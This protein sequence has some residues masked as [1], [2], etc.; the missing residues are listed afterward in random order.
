MP[1]GMLADRAPAWSRVVARAR[2]GAI[3]DT[4]RGHLK[5][6]EEAVTLA[7]DESGPPEAPSLLCV[8]DARHGRWFWEGLRTAL[9]DY[10][11][12]V[13]DLPGHG[14]SADLPF[15]SIS[16]CADRLVAL[17]RARAHKRVVSAIGVGLGAQI[18]LDLMARHPGRIGRAVLCRARVR[19]EPD[20]GLTRWTRR[21]AATWPG[22]QARLATRLRE[23][24]IPEPLHASWID[25]DKRLDHRTQ[26]RLRTATQ[27]F[28]PPAG[29][30][31]VAVPTLLLTGERE[32]DIVRHSAEDLVSL[33][34]HA[35]SGT[36]ADSGPWWPLATPE[37]VVAA[38]RAWLEQR[39]LPEAIRH[40]TAPPQV[41]VPDGP[42]APPPEEEDG[43]WWEEAPWE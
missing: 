4:V 15:V 36:V 41:T 37:L 24:G 16:D 18:L 38:V 40:L 13:P 7:C 31:D 34:R 3:T 17:I 19:P 29:V 26:E 30:T 21:L 20:T 35:R 12:L 8:H 6:K 2:S 11:A 32:S 25:A 43:D 1:S 28:T 39:P 5:E 14:E 9:P 10:H 27:T 42:V 33:M 23:H 22:R